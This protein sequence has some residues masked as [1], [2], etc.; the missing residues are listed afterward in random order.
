[1]NKQNNNMDDIIIDNALDWYIKHTLFTIENKTADDG[2]TDY[3]KLYYGLFNG[4]NLII[5]NT[6]SHDQTIEALKHLL[7]KAEDYYLSV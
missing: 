5:E 7:N 3:K 2:K 1:M 6:C 4:I